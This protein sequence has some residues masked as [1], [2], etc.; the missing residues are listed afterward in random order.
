[1]VIHG[2]GQSAGAFCLQCQNSCC[3][4]QGQQHRSRFLTDVYFEEIRI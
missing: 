2:D 3:F 4:S 1:M